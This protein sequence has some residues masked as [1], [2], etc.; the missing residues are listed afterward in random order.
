MSRDLRALLVVVLIF[1]AGAIGYRF[2]FAD[3]TV[4]RFRVVTVVGSVQHIVGGGAGA[5]ARP[6]DAIEAGDRIVS[7][8]G[9]MA[10]LGLGGDTRVT[11]DANSSVTIRGVSAEGVKLELEGGKVRATVRPG[12]GRVDILSAGR[13]VG[14]DDA[15]FTAVVDEEG[16]LAIRSERGGVAVSGMGG[17]VALKQGEDLVALGDGSSPLVAPASEAL[18]LHVA[19]PAVTRTRAGEVEVGGTTQP[20]A[21]VVVTGGARPITVKAGRDGRYRMKVPLA[22]GPNALRVSATS[23]LG[24]AAEVASAEVVRDTTAPSIGV[25]LEF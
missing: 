4:D 19:W 13:E 9:S 8:D 17:E 5:A 20:G 10:V 7:G 2:L 12:S 24:R 11:V 1:A 15:D 18:L 25:T 23:L 3:E 14:A 22:E 16:T 6:G 21:T